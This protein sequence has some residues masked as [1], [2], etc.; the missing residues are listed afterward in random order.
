M[1]SAPLFNDL[2]GGPEDALAWRVTTHDG[3][4]LRLG[5]WNRRGKKGTV[6]LFPGRTEYIEK[7]GIT[8][9]DLAKAGFATFSID[10]RGQGLSD[11]L[12]PNPHAGHIRDF[13]DYQLDV[14]AMIKTAN[15]ADL[16]RPFYLLSHSMGGAIALRALIN[17]LRVNAAVFS[18][19]MW[20]IKMSAFQRMI[21]RPLSWLG[22]QIGLGPHI[23]PGTTKNAY[24]LSESFETNE[25]TRDPAMYERMIQHLKSK[26]EL[27]LGGPT[28]RWINEALRD[29]RALAKHPSPTVPCLTL[30]GSDETIVCPEKIPEHMARWPNS[31]LETFD[32]CRHEI[33]MDTP[34]IRSTAT[35]MIID[36]FQ[37]HQ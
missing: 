10:W 21:A 12:A 3:I 26:P 1:Q 9:T 19:P 7:Y 13:G 17:D 31:H 32:G 15:A 11:R 8:A 14:A 35:Q 22:C 34:E 25:L 24:V 16:P 20:G 5:L 28:Y 27:I 36:H 33:L 2:A 4:G 30:L 29:M 6:L 37:R 18:A 23:A